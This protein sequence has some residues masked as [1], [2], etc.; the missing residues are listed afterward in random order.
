VD[1]GGGGGGRASS[2]RAIFRSGAGVVYSQ[3]RLQAHKRDV[4]RGCFA[5]GAGVF[6][7]FTTNQGGHA[8]SAEGPEETMR[9]PGVAYEVIRPR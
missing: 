1:W 6:C 2:G 8:H 4:G 5:Y 7:I 9:Y 3:K